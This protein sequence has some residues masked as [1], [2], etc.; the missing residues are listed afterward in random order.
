M[1]K[2]VIRNYFKFYTVSVPAPS[3]MLEDDLQLSD[4]EDSDG[5]QV[6]F[7]HLIIPGSL[8]NP[9]NVSELLILTCCLFFPGPPSLTVNA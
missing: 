4:S 5:E 2:E 7:V 9:S 3:S 8:L 1:L 6:S